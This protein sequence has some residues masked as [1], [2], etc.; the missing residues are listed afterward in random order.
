MDF[1]AVLERYPDNKRTPDA[2]FMKGMAL[3][4]SGQRDKAATEWRTLRKKFPRSD[5]SS[6]AAEQLRAMGLSTGATTAAHKK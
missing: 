6:Q 2:Y 1:D 4:F 5:A 3:K